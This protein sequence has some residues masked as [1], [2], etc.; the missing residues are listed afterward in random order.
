M[1]EYIFYEIQFQSQDRT[2][3]QVS[4]NIYIKITILKHT[5]Q[6]RY[7]YWYSSISIVSLTLF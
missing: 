5:F 2:Q 3:D 1:L 6:N 7:L 4:E